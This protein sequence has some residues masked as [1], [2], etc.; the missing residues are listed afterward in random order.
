MSYSTMS[1]VEGKTTMV[2]S[3]SEDAPITF[4]QFHL[5][6]RSLH[7]Y[8]LGK[9][10]PQEEENC[11]AV[12]VN[13]FANM[14]NARLKLGDLSKFVSLERVS[15]TISPEEV[16]DLSKLRSIYKF[17]GATGEEGSEAPAKPKKRKYKNGN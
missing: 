6:V 12:T 4:K 11:I 8:K 3:L 10:A 16:P 7:G 17:G 9:I 14:D 2:Y 15:D 1:Q 5:I 13:Y